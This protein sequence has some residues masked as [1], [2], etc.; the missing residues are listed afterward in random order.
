MAFVLPGYG[1]VKSS[2]S[3]FQSAPLLNTYSPRVFGSPPQLTN[4]CDMRLASSV[5]GKPGPVG[6][7]YL[8]KILRGSQMANFV[9]GK[10]LFTGG[11]NKHSD[12][13]LTYYKYRSAMASYGIYGKDGS[14]VKTDISTISDSQ[15]ALDAYKAA[16][17]EEEGTKNSG[18]LGTLSDIFGND[19]IVDTMSNQMS[20]AFSYGAELT[21]ESESLL[22]DLAS[23]FGDEASTLFTALKASAK[24]QQPFYT[25]DSD[26][27]SYINN[28]KMMIN[29]AV[30]MLGLQ[31]AVVREGDKLYGVGLDAKVDNDSDVWSNYRPIT[32]NGKTGAGTGT[33]FDTM[34]GDTNQYVSFMID[35]TGADETYNNSWGKST[36]FNTMTEGESNGRELAFITNSTSSK[37]DDEVIKLVKGTQE[38]V[39]NVLKSLSS[40]TGRFTAAVLG[41]MVSSYL[42]DHIVYPDVYQ[43]SDATTSTTITTHLVAS[44][45]DPYSYLT[46]ILVPIFFALGL[47][48]P[49][50]SVT[51]NAAYSFPPLVQCTIPGMWGTRLGGVQQISV[52]KNSSG[53]DVSI[54]GFPLSVDLSITVVSLEHSLATSGMDKTSVFL[55]NNTMF[56]YIAQCA[57][58]DKYRVNGSMRLV[59]KLALAASNSL[60]GN[61]FYNLGNAVMSDI[62]GIVNSKIIQSG[63]L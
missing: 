4:L 16:L 22:H 1:Q 12:I 46:E 29:A 10:A 20:T 36:L 38:T 50:M 3:A 59:T 52:K 48:L 60:S 18:I 32:V 53:K 28:V 40:G 58:V 30:V 61:L 44:G 47:V 25:F 41:G 26:W 23:V 17:G 35:N 21:G 55:N 56:D 24:V 14:E 9:V 34:T 37:L 63:Q 19:D 7:Y 31:D 49:S 62:A 33:A 8:N 11:T 13:L 51:N 5:D 57:G 27:N 15:A 54:H 6:D 42:G 39:N 43:G 45:G 2:D